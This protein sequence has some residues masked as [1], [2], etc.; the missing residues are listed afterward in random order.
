MTKRHLKGGALL[1]SLC[2]LIA[3]AFVLISPGTEPAIH[4]DQPE[5]YQAGDCWFPI[6]EGWQ[7]QCGHMHTEPARGGFV[8]PVVVI[9]DSSTDRR[10]DPLVYLTGGPGSSSFLEPRNIEHWFYWLETADLSRDLVLVDQR[11][12]GLSKP[13]FRCH[14]HDAGLR[15]LLGKD[16]SLLE[17]YRAQFQTLGECVALMAAAGWSL[18]HFSTS[19]SAADMS[20]VMEALGYEQWNVMGVSYG[21]RLALEWLRQDENRIR[22][23]ILDSVYPL[24]KGSLTEWP[25]LLD[26]SM[27]AFWIHCEAEGW[28]SEVGLADFL[29]AVEQLQSEPRSLVVPL[30]SGG[31]PVR[32]VLNGHRFL[33]TVYS[34]LYD[35]TLHQHIPLAIQEVLTT[36]DESLKKLVSNAVN[37]QF[38]E[39]F[40]PMV[41]AAV[42]C[43]ETV[44]LSRDDYESARF[45]YPR[46][47]SFTEHAWDFDMCH[48]VPRRDD[49]ESFRQ[50]V[51]SKVPAL[52]LSGGLDPV[53]PA[54]WAH[55]LAAVMPNAQH[56]HVPDIGHGVVASRACIHQALGEFLDAPEQPQPFPCM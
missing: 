38:A 6:P 25:Q 11:G 35:D 22:T 27:A 41:Y 39:E 3:I 50:A 31:W 40:N 32:V 53:T 33:G 12:T 7:V 16:L 24:D 29:S 9:R 56:W 19:H 36:G 5:G 28:C 47:A 30:H 17:E 26:S 14:G 23:L 42:E 54:S 15:A 8:L 48:H 20:A 44:D 2:L 13:K 21:S 18:E 51:P 45:N 4:T 34:A 49:L 10:P 37:S 55:E 46:W 52:I 1:L 43:T